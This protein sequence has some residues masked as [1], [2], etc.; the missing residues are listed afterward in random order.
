[1]HNTVFHRRRAERLAQLLEEAGRRRHSRSPLDDE[2]AGYVELGQRMRDARH[3]VDATPEEDFRSSLRAMLVATAQREGIGRAAVGAPAPGR[4]TVGA[5]Q[6]VSHG[7]QDGSRP[8]RVGLRSRRTRGAIIVGL[9]AGTLA[10]SGMS[11]ASGDAMPGDPLY[12]VKR[13]TESARLALT[14]TDMMRGQVY[15]D[16]AGTR[17]NEARDRARRADLT[18][19]ASLL[20]AMD[21]QTIQG[22]ELLSGWAVERHDT[23]ALDFIDAWGTTQRVRLAGLATGTSAQRV[24]Q[25]L[26]LLSDVQHRSIKLRAALACG[27]A[28][29]KADRLGP[30]PADCAASGGGGTHGGGSGSAG[31]AGASPGSSGGGSDPVV[32]APAGG[33]PTVTPSPTVN[34]QSSPTQATNP[35][36]PKS[37]KPS[38]D[39]KAGGTSLT[40]L[41]GGLL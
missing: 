20:G 13:S 15:L 33:D 3:P 30:V 26:A 18:G 37:A 25:S 31:S 36:L 12:A 17:A 24:G 19:V 35:Q 39:H 8:G 2:L 6:A 9:A 38:P 21:N 40:G 7:D 4:A 5:L 16:L 28:T 41:L 1:M 27:A 29:G 22:I 32:P 23:A 10:L 11:A 34:P 14:T